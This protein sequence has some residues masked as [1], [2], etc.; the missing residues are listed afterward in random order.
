[1][2]AQVSEQ[3]LTEAY[4]RWMIEEIR[5]SFSAEQLEKELAERQAYLGQLDRAISS[6][7]DAIERAPASTLTQRLVEREEERRL[8]N[9]DI[10]ALAGNQSYYRSLQIDDE[11]LDIL[12]RELRKG[13][14]ADRHTVRDTLRRVVTKVEI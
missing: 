6:L 5:C 12:I 2:V 11:T 3:V 9:S 8:L 10:D 4:L 13:L 7:V 14:L 1:V